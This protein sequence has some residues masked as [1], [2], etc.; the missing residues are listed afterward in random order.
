MAKVHIN[1]D[2]NHGV[3]EERTSVISQ[4]NAEIEMT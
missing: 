2:I 3:F 4:R 1:K